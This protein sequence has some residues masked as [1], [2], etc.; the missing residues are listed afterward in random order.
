MFMI[1]QCIR[2]ELEVNHSSDIYSNNNTNKAGNSKEK[3]LPGC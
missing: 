3:K 1:S 2:Y